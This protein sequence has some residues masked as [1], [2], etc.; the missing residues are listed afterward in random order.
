MRQILLVVDPG[1][2]N[3]ATVD[4]A[5]FLATLSQS[6][7][8]VGLLDNIRKIQP[9]P[10]GSNEGEDLLAPL[11]EWE[12][13]HEGN[14]QLTESIQFLHEAC[15]RREVR[16]TVHHYPGHPAKEVA[17]ESRYADLLVVDPSLSFESKSEG[18]PTDFIL[19]LLGETECPVVIAPER[20]DGVEEIVFACDYGP[21]AMFALRQFAYLFP[22]LGSRPLTVLNVS[23]KKPEEEFARL[24]AWASNYFATTQCKTIHH[25]EKSPATELMAEL[26]SR[27]HVLVIAGAF[28]RS[29]FSRLLHQSKAEL[30]I[31]TLNQPLFIAHR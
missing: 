1:C 25:A 29:A 17:R 14:E 24:S 20:F 22:E 27:D 11:A 13:R 28:G 10:A 26:I 12:A 3:T 30:L 2:I 8:Q 16:C 6:T 21:S 5:C 19:R 18:I 31:K 9:E 4:L 7:L 15:A 23:E